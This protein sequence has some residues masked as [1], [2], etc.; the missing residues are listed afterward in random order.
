MTA[1][2]RYG[3]TLCDCCALPTYSCGRTAEAHIRTEKATERSRLLTLPNV[4]PARHDGRCADCGEPFEPG[5]PINRD[6][7]AL[8][9]DPQWRSLECCPLVGVGA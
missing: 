8:P 9:G 1:V 5:T 6:P 4:T 7:D 2:N 3:E